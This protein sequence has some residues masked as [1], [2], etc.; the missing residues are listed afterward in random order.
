MA[1]EGYEVASC[2][3]T[4]GAI[5]ICKNLRKSQKKSSRGLTYLIQGDGEF[6]D[7]PGGEG[8]KLPLCSCP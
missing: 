3:D 7:I 2:V 6:G 4:Q 1:F 5:D 8:S